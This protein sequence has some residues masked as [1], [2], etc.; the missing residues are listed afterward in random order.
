MNRILVPTLLVSLLHLLLFTAIGIAQSG[1]LDTTFGVG[2]WVTTSV[3]YD[4]ASGWANHVL[5]QPDGKIV[6]AVTSRN[7]ENT[8]TSDFYVVRYDS[9]GALDASFGVGGIVRFAFS[10]AA[11]GENPYALA[12][13]SDGKI[14]VGGSVQTGGLAGLARLNGDGSLDPS[15]GTGGKLTFTF[16]NRENARLTSI[17]VQTNGKI[18]VGGSSGDIKYGF[19]RLNSNGTFDTTFNVSGKTTITGYSKSSQFLGTPSP[20]IA[21]QPDGKYVIA[22]GTELIRKV[23]LSW[24]VMRLNANGSLDSSF[25]SGGMAV[26]PFAGTWSMARNV[27]V[28]PDGK[29]L[30]GGDWLAGGTSGNSSWVFIRYLANGQLDT[31]FGSGG[32]AIFSSPNFRRMTGMAVLADGRV[33]G[34]GF[35]R[36]PDSTNSNIMLMRILSDGSVDNSFG[37]IGT[38]YGDYGG[39]HDNGTSMA[40]SPDGKYVVAGQLLGLPN[41][42]VEVSRYLP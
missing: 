5:A 39:L 41:A 31:S 12:L 26:T 37:T 23:T 36:A 15:F 24:T 6:V 10:A 3:N 27:S 1:S 22:G 34:G 40:L 11:D 14:L 16:A 13:Q 2:G 19:A 29:I 21:F 35:D 38:A 42:L 20:R 8:E 7:Y 30:A 18:I 28:L 9:N 4:T 17:A 32:K 25:G 33:V